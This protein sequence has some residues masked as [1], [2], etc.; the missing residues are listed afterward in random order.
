MFTG[1][2]E[3]L[4]RVARVERRPASL[5]LEVDAGPLA[6]TVAAGESV[7]V[8]G[9]CLTAVRVEG[10]RVRFDVITETVE[11]TGL[12]RLAPGDPVNLE[13]AMRADG[14][15]GGHFVTGHV[16]GVG[17]VAARRETEGQTALGIECPRALTDLMIPKGSVAVD[18]VSLTLADLRDGGF[19]V[20]LIPRTLE[21][22]T[23]G[24]RRVGDEVNIEVDCL[25]KWVKRLLAG[26]RRIEG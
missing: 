4:G 5:G 19:G 1:I 13:L 14:R 18:G 17:R 9:V 2:V 20:C 15:F 26:D 24:S 6:R 16:D 8:L 25:G 21:V 22:T 3:H 7:C 12:G 23:L 11:R 10:P